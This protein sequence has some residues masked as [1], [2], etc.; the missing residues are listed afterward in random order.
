MILPPSPIGSGG[1]LQFTL[2]KGRKITQITTFTPLTNGPGPTHV[3]LIEDDDVLILVDTGIPTGLLKDIFFLCRR[4]NMPSMIKN[5]PNDCSEKELIRGINA[6]GHSP[7]DIDLLII[8][9]GHPDHYMLGNM[10]VEKSGAKVL[11]HLLDTGLLYNPWGF[12]LEEVELWPKM[13]ITGMPMPEGRVPELKKAINKIIIPQINRLS[14]KV[15][16]AIIY[17]GPLALTEYKSEWIEVRNF[18][19]HTQGALCLI[20]GVD[21]EEERA[22]ICGDTVLYPI[23]PHPD[24]LVDYL[25]TLG[26][27]RMIGGVSL[28]LPA[29]GDC[30]KHLYKRASSLEKHHYRRL[31]ITYDFCRTPKCAW[32]IASLPGYFDVF[33]DPIKFNPLAAKEILMH[34]EL[35]EKA[36]GIFRSH[37]DGTTVYFQNRG[38]PFRKVKEKVMEIVANREFARFQ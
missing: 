10:I 21:M 28:V 7:R 38:L 37:F 17:D 2:P 22:M 14:L 1:V 26:N 5:L 29:H 11:A 25:A 32:E 6:A 16:R 27:L 8:T 19:G 30:I 23:S 35:L 20:L 13:V 9:H 33:I 4:Q 3:Y 24:D 36:G 18:P 12:I 15:D 31:K 34:L